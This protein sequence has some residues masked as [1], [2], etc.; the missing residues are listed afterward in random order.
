[1]DA[2]RNLIIG[3]ACILC[4]GCTPGIRYRP[5]EIPS[6]TATD[7]QFIQQTQQFHAELLQQQPIF[8]NPSAARRVSRILD[9][10]LDVT[11]STGHWTVTLI[12]DPAF[13]AMVAPGNYM[14]VFRGLLDQTRNDDEVAAVLAHEIAHRLAQ[15]EIKRS[16]QIWGE[17]LATLATV[18]TGVAVASQQG[19]TPRDVQEMMEVTHA[20]GAGF[21]SLRYEKDQER[22]ADQ[23]GMFLMADAG[24][25]PMAAADVWAG[26][27]AEE[28]TGGSDFFSTHPL[29]EDRYAMAVKLLPLAQVRYQEA[30]QRRKT[31]KRRKAIPPP[32]PAVSYQIDQAQQALANNDLET[33]STIARSLTSKAPT[34][35]DV[36]NLL[37]IVKAT[38]GETKQ[39]HKAFQKGLSIAPDDPI[40]RYN[41]GC[42]HARHGERAQ[43]LRAL[44]QAFSLQPSLTEGAREDPDL[45]SLYEDPAFQALL[46]RQYLVPAPSNIGGNSFTVN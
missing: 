1:M 38:K 7:P 24:I 9:K 33:A 42:M 29:H 14:Y 5:G 10:L 40:L 39:A 43:A 17:A 6:P 22:E 23:I 41:V 13:N 34:S 28:G 19:S 37:G 27:I 15:H 4:I 44:E 32:S 11:P 35:P 25:N 26:R 31:G 3:L 2:L 18:A 46:E 36:Y 16:G 12:D 45:A 30:L 21:T 8:R 20:L